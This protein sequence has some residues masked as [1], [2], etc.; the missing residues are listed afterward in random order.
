[1][2]GFLFRAIEMHF[3]LT[4][5]LYLWSYLDSVWGK[6]EKLLGLRE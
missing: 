1:M 4:L 6:E 3:T 5:S 2:E